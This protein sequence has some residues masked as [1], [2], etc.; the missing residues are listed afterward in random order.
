MHRGAT[1][2]PA[3]Q[4]LGRL[5][6]AAVGTAHRHR[7]GQGHSLPKIA[8]LAPLA[9][10][11]IK[12]GSLIYLGEGEQAAF[13]EIPVMRARTAGSEDFSKGLASFVEKR[14]GVSLPMTGPPGCKQ[15]S[16]VETTLAGYFEGLA[17]G[18]S[19]GGGSGCAPIPCTASTTARN[20]S[21]VRS[22]GI[23]S[24]RDWTATTNSSI[25]G[26]K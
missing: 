16:Y 18:R 21:R 3:R 20:W 23:A 26:P 2:A 7:R 4:D 24:M 13:A 17:R 8:T 9:G 5:E 1:P 11:E 6:D 22:L 19:I 12:R 14:T 15:R 25:N 10:Q